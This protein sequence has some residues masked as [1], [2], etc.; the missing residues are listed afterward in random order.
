ML[1]T[2]VYRLFISVVAHI[3]ITTVI[4]LGVDE[5]LVHEHM[6]TQ[7]EMMGDNETVPSPTLPAMS[8]S[9]T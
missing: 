7:G 1:G 3:V 2:T 6:L 8:K 4:I 5:P 9:T